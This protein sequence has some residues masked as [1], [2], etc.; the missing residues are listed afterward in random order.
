MPL[1]PEVVVMDAVRF[2][3]MMMPEAVANSK[4]QQAA[5]L[6]NKA[7]SFLRDFL[8]TKGNLVISANGCSSRRV[9]PCFA[10]MCTFRS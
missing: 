8:I 10:V 4:S 2:K 7:D 6:Q 9:E 3:R 5:Y 1:D